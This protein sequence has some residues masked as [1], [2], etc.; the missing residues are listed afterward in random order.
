MF[1]SVFVMNGQ[2]QKVEIT[3]VKKAVFDKAKSKYKS[4]LIEDT[5]TIRKVDKKI[6]LPITLNKPIILK[7]TLVE[8][9]DP[10]EKEYNYYGQF[11][12]EGFYLVGVR[13]WESYEY[14][15]INK[16]TG[17]QTS[18]WDF[19]ELSSQ[20]VFFA[21]TS[22]P[23]GMEGQTN[24]LQIWKIDKSG[25][26]KLIKYFETDQDKWIPFKLYWE[27]DKSIIL[28]VIEK[29]KFNY[30]ESDKEPEYSY[31]RVRIK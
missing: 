21:N 2:N 31:L 24:G 14:F 3:P 23:Y 4:A 12:N 26:G 8:I 5:L 16:K 19:P 15:L 10:D 9:G 18:L 27:S 6:T 22:L 7:D 30:F 25:N 1:F 20:S 11:K 29:E 17:E 13:Y 28:Q